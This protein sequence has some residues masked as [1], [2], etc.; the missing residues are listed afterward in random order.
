[1]VF[2]IDKSENASA[3][4]D[5]WLNCLEE[6]CGLPYM[7]L[8]FKYT[9][10]RMV[11]MALL[12]HQELGMLSLACWHPSVFNARG[13]FDTEKVDGQD[14]VYQADGVFRSTNRGYEEII[15]KMYYT[16]RASQ[17]YEL[18]L[19]KSDILTPQP[20][21]SMDATSF[22]AL[23]GGITQFMYAGYRA[24]MFAG[25]KVYSIKK[26]GNLLLVGFGSEY[27]PRMQYSKDELGEKNSGEWNQFDIRYRNLGPTPE[28]MTLRLAV[29]SLYKGNNTYS[30]TEHLTSNEASNEKK[31][32]G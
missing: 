30:G 20:G 29:L 26:M 32:G 28:Q 12:A 10:H 6:K 1:M 27:E 11:N 24:G 23:G 5:G 16:V 7:W 21:E 19:N 13:I 2:D 15:H 25:G 22:G 17:N 14:I 18:G 3:G 31:L 9:Y 4:D 8:P